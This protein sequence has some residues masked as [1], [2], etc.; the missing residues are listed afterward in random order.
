MQRLLFFG[1]DQFIKCTFETYIC[2]PHIHHFNA[3]YIIPTKYCHK[4]V[5]G[6]LHL[7][8]LAQIMTEI[9]ATLPIPPHDTEASIATVVVGSHVTHVEFRPSEADYCHSILLPKAGCSASPLKKNSLSVNPSVKDTYTTRELRRKE[10]SNG[11]QH[12]T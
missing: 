2:K 5:G 8:Q 6:I 11:V 1:F 10:E 12:V 7:L 4:V 3:T 9:L